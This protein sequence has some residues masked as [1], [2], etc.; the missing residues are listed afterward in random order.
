MI[1]ALSS[2]RSSELHY[3][4]SVTNSI[5]VATNTKCQPNI[6]G[7]PLFDTKN[8]DIAYLLRCNYC[9]LLSDFSS[10][11]QSFVMFQYILYSNVRMHNIQKKE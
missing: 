9:H 10:M 8:Y 11:F 1:N 2:S 3:I 5:C 7:H 4:F 6:D